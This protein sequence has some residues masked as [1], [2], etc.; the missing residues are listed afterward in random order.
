MTDRL[1]ANSSTASDIGSSNRLVPT[2]SK[3]FARGKGEL[4]F[5]VSDLLTKTHGPIRETGVLTAHET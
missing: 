2:I 3:S 5:G 4:M 1:P